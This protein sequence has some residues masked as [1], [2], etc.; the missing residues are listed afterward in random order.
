MDTLAGL[1]VVK[2][3]SIPAAHS[4]TQRA[5]GIGR[6][7]RRPVHFNYNVHIHELMSGCML[8]HTAVQSA[9]PVS[10]ELGT[11][12]IKDPSIMP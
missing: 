3:E 2:A 10:A 8:H 5:V 12:T 4:A 9:L 1:D 11:V 7:V 6:E